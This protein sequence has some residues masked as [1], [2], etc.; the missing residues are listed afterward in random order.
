MSPFVF[1]S[2]DA[3]LAATA[4]HMQQADDLKAPAK[5]T[6]RRRRQAPGGGSFSSTPFI[7]F[8][9]TPQKNKNK[10][11]SIKNLMIFNSISTSN[12]YRLAVLFAVSAITALARTRIIVNVR[13]G[14][15]CW[16]EDILTMCV[17]MTTSWLIFLN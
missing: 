5:K 13:S 15:C 11:D 17:C 8:L 3:A 7:K 9:S 4:T 14:W 2:F 6:S 10:L 1:S 16:F 12:T